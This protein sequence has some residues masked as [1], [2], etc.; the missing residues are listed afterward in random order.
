VELGPR[1]VRIPDMHVLLGV[2][3][4]LLFLPP[5]AQVTHSS[6]VSIEEGRAGLW[7]TDK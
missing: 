5:P 3:L 6:S 7:Q 1:S 2:P 4:R